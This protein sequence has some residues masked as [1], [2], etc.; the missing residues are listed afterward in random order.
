M[1]MKLIA[2]LCVAA[3]ALAAC[4]R[5]NVQ[6]SE[7]DTSYRISFGGTVGYT[8]VNVWT[9]PETRC[10]SYVTDDGF[11]SP[12]LNADGTQRCAAVTIAAR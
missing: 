10:Q 3:V 12:R 4:G 11:M 8:Y 1:K 5:N 6:Y 9:D 7:T 2:G